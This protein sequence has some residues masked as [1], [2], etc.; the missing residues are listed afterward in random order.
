MNTF[1]FINL[2]NELKYRQQKWRIEMITFGETSKHT[3]PS[4]VSCSIIV[5]YFINSLKL[6]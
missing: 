3:A 1:Y 5:Y 4:E 2:E 6:L